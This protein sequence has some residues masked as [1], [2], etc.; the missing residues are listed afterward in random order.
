[1]LLGV[2]FFFMVWPTLAKINLVVFS[3]V[4]FIL[5]QYLTPL[6]DGC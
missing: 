6:S 5:R 3:T 2:W 4:C 1:M